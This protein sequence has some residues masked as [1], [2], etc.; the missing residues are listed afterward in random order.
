MGRD[1]VRDRIASLEGFPGELALHLEH[2]ILSHHGQREWGAVEEPHT[3]EAIALHQAD[4]LSARLNQA[5]QVI[6]SQQTH[7]NW[8]QFDRH[9]GRSLFTPARAVSRSRREQPSASGD[10]NKP[11]KVKLASG[12]VFT[13]PEA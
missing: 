11:D 10:C 13:P 3:I 6:K 2:L 12:G 7:S 9:L 1:F 5:A 4:L 8:T